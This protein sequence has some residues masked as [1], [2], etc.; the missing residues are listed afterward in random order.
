MDRLPVRGQ[1]DA[2]HSAGP[3]GEGTAFTFTFAPAAGVHMLF[4]QAT[5]ADDR[6]NTDAALSLACA[7]H[8]T[9]LVDLVANDNNL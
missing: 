8:D 7:F 2:R 4:A 6:A 1:R 9:P 3:P 5:C